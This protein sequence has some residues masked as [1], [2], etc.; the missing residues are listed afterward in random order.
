MGAEVEEGLEGMAGVAGVDGG[1]QVVAA[2]DVCNGASEDALAWEGAG[3]V[4]D[5]NA[6]AFLPSTA[7]LLPNGKLPWCSGGGR[8]GRSERICSWGAD[9]DDDGCNCGVDVL[10]RV[11]RLM[12]AIVAL[13]NAS[14]ECAQNR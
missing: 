9:I 6:L 12:R 1:H 5:D 11:E 2:S 14:V 8:G 13:F 3:F 4:V 7:V 10:K